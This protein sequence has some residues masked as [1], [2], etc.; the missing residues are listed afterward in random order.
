MRPCDLRFPRHD[1]AAEFP[2]FAEGVDIDVRGHQAGPKHPDADEAAA[3]PCPEPLSGHPGPRPRKSELAPGKGLPLQ[4]GGH[5]L[6]QHGHPRQEQKCRAQDRKRQTRR[7]NACRLQGCQ[8]I[9]GGETRESEQ[10][11]EQ[12]ADGRKTCHAAGNGQ[13]HKENCIPGRIDPLPHLI[14][15]FHQFGDAE[16]GSHKQGNQRPAPS[17]PAADIAVDRLHSPPACDRRRRWKNPAGHL[18]RRRTKTRRAPTAH[19]MPGNASTVPFSTH[20][21]AMRA[22]L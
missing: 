10:P 2:I 16:E 8:L 5:E 14:Q 17:Q 13:E 22:R 20:F 18:N 7:G 9:A 21:F 19:Q 12:G 3:V 11:P 6:D 15:L 4:R 1:M